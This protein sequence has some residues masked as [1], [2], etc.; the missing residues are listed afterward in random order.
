MAVI[1]WHV[2]IFVCYGPE[3]F[4]TKVLWSKQVLFDGLYIRGYRRSCWIMLSDRI[5]G[6]RDV[7]VC[8]CVKKTEKQKSQN[9]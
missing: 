5:L 6:Q 2:E 9:P 3:K 7:S 4:T 1:Q 8:V